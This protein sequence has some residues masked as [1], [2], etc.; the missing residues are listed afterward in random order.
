MPSVVEGIYLPTN[1]AKVTDGAADS[2]RLRSVEAML[3]RGPSFASQKNRGVASMLFDTA[4][5][6]GLYVIRRSRG[7]KGVLLTFSEDVIRKILTTYWMLT[8]QLSDLS[9]CHTLCFATL[10]QYGADSAFLSSQ[11]PGQRSGKGFHRV[12]LHFWISGSLHKR[13][14]LSASE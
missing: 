3:G 13:R 2:V 14:H 4:I 11:I 7:R 1:K 10:N 9:K 6:R 8:F 5:L 12:E